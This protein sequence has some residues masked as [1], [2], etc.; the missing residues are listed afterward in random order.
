MIDASPGEQVRV[1]LAGNT[2]EGTIERI[3][4]MVGLPGATDD[5][6]VSLGDAR[7]TVPETLVES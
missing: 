3:K 2:V 4:P 1:T 6:V 5:V 7:V